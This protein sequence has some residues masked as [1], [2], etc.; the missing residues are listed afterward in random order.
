M[1]L[2]ICFH[3]SMYSFWY[4]MWVKKFPIPSHSAWFIGLGIPSMGMTADKTGRDKST[5]DSKGCIYIYMLTDI[6]RNLM[7]SPWSPAKNHHFSLVFLSEIAILL[8]WILSLGVGGDVQKTCEDR[9]KDVV[10]DPI[11][12]WQ[13]GKTG[14]FMGRFSGKWW[15]KMADLWS[16]WMEFL[17][18]MEMNLQK[19]TRDIFIFRLRM[20]LL[21]SG[22]AAVKIRM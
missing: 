12:A 8:R 11:E 17:V 2:A 5:G 7:R 16:F 18:K 3:L 14:L 1:F 21:K 13:L 19:S 4:S 6:R 10:R 9:I 22:T 15:E 20:F